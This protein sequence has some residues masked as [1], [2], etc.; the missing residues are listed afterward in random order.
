MNE[1]RNRRR[2]SQRQRRQNMSNSARDHLLA[3]RRNQE[4]PETIEQ[5]NVRHQ[6]Y[7]QR[8][9]SIEGTSTSNFANYNTT[10]SRLTHIRQIA[11]SRS[12]EMEGTSTKNIVNHSRTLRLSCIRQQARLL[13]NQRDGSI[14]TTQSN[15]NL[16]LL[17]NCRVPC[18]SSSNA[19]PF[20]NRHNSGRN[21]PAHYNFQ[22]I[23]LEEPKNCSYCGA[24]LFV[25]ETLD[26]CCSNGKINLPTPENPQELINIFLDQTDEGKHFRENIRSYNHVFCFTSIGVNIDENLASGRQGVFT[27]R[28]QGSIYH[29]IGSLLPINESRPI[30]LQMYI[31][32]TQNEIEHRH[33]E[34]N[35]T[36]PSLLHK[37]K[38]ILDA[39]NP[40]VQ[41]FRQLGRREDV[42]NS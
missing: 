6:R 31:Y 36:R 9:N 39:H 23:I 5:R 12:S 38:L 1:Q 15:Q 20:P 33:Q 25:H 4:T 26:L 10:A 2:L 42:M 11:R 22:T 14:T 34:R 35:I 28:A 13:C 32:D 27:Y 3:A 18:S 21:F 17:N 41:V 29:R 30:F 40:Y 8:Y 37:L 16:T 7:L 24:R 19:R